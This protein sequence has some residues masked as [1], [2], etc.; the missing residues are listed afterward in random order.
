MKARSFLSRSR[1]LFVGI[2]LLFAFLFSPQLR[3]Q[4]F[5]GFYPPVLIGLPDTVSI[6][7]SVLAGAVLGNISP[8]AYNN[9]IT[10]TGY[11]DT[12]AGNIPF[13]PITYSLLS[14]N[15]FDTI[16]LLIFLDIDNTPQQGIFRIGGNVIVIWPILSDPQFTT[17]D[18]IAVP[19]F[20]R[21]PSSVAERPRTNRQV[22]CYPNP[23]QTKLHIIAEPGQSVPEEIIVRDIH[24]RIIYTS[25]YSP[26]PINTETWVSG[27]Y[28]IECR[29]EDGSSSMTRVIR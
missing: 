21:G 24:A 26:Q 13:P 9:S 3:A 16:P 7:D 27:V 17:G 10:I 2:A 29:F 14:I 5:I 1:L 20:V 19:V 15:A 6:G 28:F 4:N 23:T 18:S 8:I 25:P 11:V 22:R 12:G